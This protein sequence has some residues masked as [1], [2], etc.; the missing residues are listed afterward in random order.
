MASYAR[1][2]INRGE[3][4]VY[5]A[6]VSHWAFARSYIIAAACA[7]VAT[8]IIWRSHEGASLLFGAFFGGVAVIV[9]AAAL[10]RQRST[11]LVL[12]DRCIIAKWGLL[13][14]DT[15]EMT[16]D[17]VE[18][19]HVSQTLLGRLL[20]YGDVTVVGVGASLEPLHHIKDPLELRKRIGA[21]LHEHPRA[22][23]TPTQEAAGYLHS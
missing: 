2:V 11:E 12:T 9:A 16:L 10:I 22:S 23:R 18:S 19:L 17:R 1:A 13:S 7:G 20:N 21:K 14:R 3:T 4:I 15:V 8:A 6:A 5:R